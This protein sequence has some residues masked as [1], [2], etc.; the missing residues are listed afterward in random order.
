MSMF[1]PNYVG[2]SYMYSSYYTSR[3][4]H[5][6]LPLHHYAGWAFIQKEAS[7]HDWNIYFGTWIPL[8]IQ[9]VKQYLL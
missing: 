2:D 4:V 6:P 9:N 5:H 8:I 3:M 1:K 7:L